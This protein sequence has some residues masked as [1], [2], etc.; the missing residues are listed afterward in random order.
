MRR[1]T[2]KK[3]LYAPTLISVFKNKRI[4][5]EVDGGG[6]EVLAQMTFLGGYTDI[7][8]NNSP[9]FSGYQKQDVLFLLPLSPSPLPLI[10][11]NKDV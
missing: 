5:I 11:H 3:L 10:T 6:G 1:N 9:V 8:S 4:S 7:F 2:K